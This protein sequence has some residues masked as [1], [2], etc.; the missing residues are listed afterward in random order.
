VKQ[1]KAKNVTAMELK[2]GFVDTAKKTA[3]RA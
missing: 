2:R 1:F 3:V